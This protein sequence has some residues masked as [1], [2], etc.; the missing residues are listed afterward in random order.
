MLSRFAFKLLLKRK[1]KWVEM[2][3]VVLYDW[4]FNM[5]AIVR[6]FGILCVCFLFL[7][8]VF[9]PYFNHLLIYMFNRKS[10]LFMIL[11][12]TGISLPI[13]DLCQPHKYNGYVNGYHF[14]ME[15]W[16]ALH[17]KVIVPV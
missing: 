1:K 14:P 15:G 12:H 5:C 16:L 2:S 10:Y 3:F 17:W 9:I 11:G 7:F 13:L 6:L 8:I 4:S